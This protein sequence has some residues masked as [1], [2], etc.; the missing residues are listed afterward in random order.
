VPPLPH[1]RGSVVAWAA[2]AFAFLLARLV[3]VDADS[4]AHAF[5]I[6]ATCGVG[7]VLALLLELLV[8]SRI[9]LHRALRPRRLIAAVERGSVRLLDDG[10]RPQDAVRL[11][12]VRDAA[13]QEPALR[14]A[15]PRTTAAA[16]PRNSWL[17][18]IARKGANQVVLGRTD[19][20]LLVCQPDVERTVKAI[21]AIPFDRIVFMEQSHLARP[22]GYQIFIGV[23][24]DDGSSILTSHHPEYTAAVRR[25][26][27]PLVAETSC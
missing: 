4:H 14:L 7:L 10:E 1:V 16:T 20:Q 12:L 27:D 23:G 2:V 13:R 6:V 5:L 21:A 19:R 26:F 22:A 11:I 24:F 25:F 15:L 18:P 9:A 17:A 8:M 3:T